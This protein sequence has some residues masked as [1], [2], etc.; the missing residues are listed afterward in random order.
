MVTVAYEKREAQGYVTIAEATKIIGCSDSAIRDKIGKFSDLFVRTGNSAILIKE[1][2]LPQLRIDS[3]E[4]KLSR[5][6]ERA[7]SLDPEAVYGV[8]SLARELN[9]S[10][11]FVYDRIEHGLPAHKEGQTAIY[12]SEAIAFFKVRSGYVSLPQMSRIT[13]IPNNTLKVYLSHGLIHTVNFGKDPTGYLPKREADNIRSI[14]NAN[15]RSKSRKIRPK[16]R[17]W[18]DEEALEKRVLGIM[19]SDGILSENHIIANHPDVLQDLQILRHIPWEK[20]IVDLSRKFIDDLDTDTVEAILTAFNAGPKEYVP[21]TFSG[22][23][24]DNTNKVLEILDSSSPKRSDLIKAI[25]SK[26][27]DLGASVVI[28]WDEMRNFL[29]NPTDV[30]TIIARRSPLPEGSLERILSYK[31]ILEHNNEVFSSTYKTRTDDFRRY[32]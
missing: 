12:G 5:L 3:L 32:F 16:S 28:V 22:V 14:H 23:S 8:K 10:A 19:K 7:E 27:K 30:L 11:E 17:P 26:N 4:K 31:G 29:S 6:Y 13:G 9:K 1:S 25:I 15:L 21:R 20:Y 18:V 24:E 2:D